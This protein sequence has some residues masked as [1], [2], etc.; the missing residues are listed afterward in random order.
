[1][2]RLLFALLLICSTAGAQVKPAVMARQQ[3]EKQDSF[4]IVDVGTHTE[5][6][7]SELRARIDSLEVKLARAHIVVSR[8]TSRFEISFDPEGK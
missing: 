3:A 7:I 5:K 6:E 2:T 1:M 8:D 4:R